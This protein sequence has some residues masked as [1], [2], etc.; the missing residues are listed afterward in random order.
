MKKNHYTK[1]CTKDRHQLPPPPPLP[2]KPPKNQQRPKKIKP[3]DNIKT[4]IENILIYVY[5]ECKNVLP[6]VLVD[7]GVLGDLQLLQALEPKMK[8]Q[9]VE[10][11][12]VNVIHDRLYF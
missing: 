5:T 7:L 1:I 3:T 6:E 4:N 2:P 12:I 9:I 10:L 11:Y 8:Q